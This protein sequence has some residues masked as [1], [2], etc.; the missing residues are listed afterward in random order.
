MNKIKKPRGP[1][2]KVVENRLIQ[3]CSKMIFGPLPVFLREDDTLNNASL[4]YNIAGFSWVGCVAGFSETY[5]FGHKVNV[6]NSYVNDNEE[7][8]VEFILDANLDNYA[9]LRQWVML[10][11]STENRLDSNTPMGKPE[12][13]DAQR[14]WCDY[15]DIWIVDNMNN[16]IAIIR[17]EHVFL[18]NLGAITMN[19]N[20]AEEV[21]VNATF[22]YNKYSII[23]KPTDIQTI[24]HNTMLT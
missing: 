6:P 13:W 7:F 11:K 10:Y 21:K 5:F 18:Y 19:F 23:R 9:L 1:K 8:T 4:E 14:A 22:K 16:T 12:I 17:Y 2:L 15:V 24:L 20:S 3:G